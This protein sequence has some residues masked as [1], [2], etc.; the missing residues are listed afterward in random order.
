[1]N[2]SSG[3][4]LG[5][6]LLIGV[7]HFFS[8]NIRLGEGPRRHRIISFAAGISIAYLFLRLLPETYDAA[9]HLKQ[10]VFVFLLLGFAIFH[11]VEKVTYQHANRENLLRELKEV[12]SVSFFFYYFTV[13]I[14]LR[15]L[16][17]TSV[18]EGSLFLVPIAVHAA[19]STASLS[20]IHGEVRES[21]WARILLSLSTI[22]G[23]AFAIMISIPVVV[24]NMLIS[25]IAG[26]LLYIIVK[27]FLPEKKK[28][29][30]IM[31]IL[32]LAVFS[33]FNFVIMLA[34]N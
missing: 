25:L 26:A 15:N 10:W 3:L 33:V 1:M 29:Q 28:G 9:P 21:L 13:G 18:L 30:P 19:L 32:G 17:R 12:H 4:A 5:F 11:V 14:V 8:E 7:I 34:R 23:I 2:L 31:F 20:E 22:L 16:T 27:E 6:G 24:G